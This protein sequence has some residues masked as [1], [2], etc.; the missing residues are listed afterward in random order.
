[1]TFNFYSNFFSSQ[2]EQITFRHPR[3]I[4]II[5]SLAIATAPLYANTP[6]FYSEYYSNLAISWE[7]AY[8]SNQVTYI[9]LMH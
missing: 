9:K 3:L 2:S 4:A 7:Q 5:T 1:M 8:V 6:V